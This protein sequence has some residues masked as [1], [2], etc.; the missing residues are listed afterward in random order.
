MLDKE[1]ERVIRSEASEL[2]EETIE[3]CNEV[4]NRC[5]KKLLST[6]RINQVPREYGEENTNEDT[7]MILSSTKSHLAGSSL[8][9]NK[10]CKIFGKDDS[11]DAEEIVLLR[12]RIESL[13]C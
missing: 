3:K 7:S 9:Y 6:E 2:N 12:S 11:I 5:N 13:K 10:S 8:D 1:K 4:D